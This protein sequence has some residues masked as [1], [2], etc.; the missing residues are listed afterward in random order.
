MYCLD[1]LR[2]GV[3]KFTY[4]GLG[5]LDVFVNFV[6][7][8]SEMLILYGELLFEFVDDLLASLDKHAAG[9]INVI[10]LM[11]RRPRTVFSNQRRG[12]ES[13]IPTNRFEIEETV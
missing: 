1:N 5:V 7:D 6:E 2:I 12:L 9:F 10:D 8:V 11:D 13:Q 3:F 4:K